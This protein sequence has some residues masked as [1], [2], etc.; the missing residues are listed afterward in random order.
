[1][2]KYP[3]EHKINV[4]VEQKV[5]DSKICS[6]NLVPQVLTLS[7]NFKVKRKIFTSPSMRI[8]GGIKKNIL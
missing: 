5:F 2:S 4:K 8:W 3:S 6:V 7:I 1:M